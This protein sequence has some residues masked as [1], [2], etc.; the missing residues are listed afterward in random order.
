[1]LY[2]GL[3]IV[4]VNGSLRRI[5]FVYLKYSFNSKSMVE[6]WISIRLEWV[7]ESWRE[8][9]RHLADTLGFALKKGGGVTVSI[10]CFIQIL[11]VNKHRQSWGWRWRKLESHVTRMTFLLSLF[12]VLVLI[13]DY[14]T[15][16]DLVFN[17]FHVLLAFILWG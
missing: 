16:L 8:L 9:G 14:K 13:F 7:P 10:V 6:L 17:D 15:S 5:W 12:L 4:I 11:Y 1:M 2:L 3:W